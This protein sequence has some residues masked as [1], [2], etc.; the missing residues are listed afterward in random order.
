[1][2]SAQARI[3]GYHRLID[4]VAKVIVTDGVSIK[5]RLEAFR[6]LK[7]LQ[8][9][10]AVEVLAEDRTALEAFGRDLTTV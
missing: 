5:D 6:L 4:E 8:L 3:Q 10:I 1:M 7:E 9:S 2:T